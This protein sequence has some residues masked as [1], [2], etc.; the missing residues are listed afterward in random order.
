[1]TNKICLM[2]PCPKYQ[3]PD[4]SASARD[5]HVSPPA[6][7]LHACTLTSMIWGMAG[8]SRSYICVIRTM[9]S[10]H[11]MVGESIRKC[12][13]QCLSLVLCA[14]CIMGSIGNTLVSKFDA[15]QPKGYQLLLFENVLS[16]QF[17]NKLWTDWL[18]GVC[19]LSTLANFNNEMS[20]GLQ[21]SSGC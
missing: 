2:W 13:A 18:P 16:M 4:D 21:A 3:G 7:R 6:K 14:V 9:H 20:K 10:L 19:V 8:N 17:F 1:M 5:A 15:L 11:L 12:Q